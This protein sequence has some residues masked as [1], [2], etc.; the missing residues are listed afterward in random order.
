MTDYADLVYEAEEV[1]SMEN[2]H[3]IDVSWTNLKLHVKSISSTSN[4]WQ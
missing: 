1:I 4:S 2:T 3:P